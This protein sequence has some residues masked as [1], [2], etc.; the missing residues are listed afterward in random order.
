MSSV[1]DDDDEEEDDVDLYR[2]R[3]LKGDGDNAT[4][5]AQ[6]VLLYQGVAR[7][8]SNGT[9]INEEFI[10]TV[11]ED[12]FDEV[13][14]VSSPMCLCNFVSHFSSISASIVPRPLQSHKRPREVLPL[15]LDASSS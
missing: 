7:L 5:S 2:Q 10:L 9:N 14:E 13:R 1:S 4:S 11:V 8:P 3:K 6:A 15:L 12:I